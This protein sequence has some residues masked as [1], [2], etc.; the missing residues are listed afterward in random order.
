MYSDISFIGLGLIGGS[1]AKAIRSHYP[2]MKI[3]AFD[4]DASS[5][6]AA[7]NEGVADIIITE[8][9]VSAFE[10]TDVIFICTPVLCAEPYVRE[11]SEAK[12]SALITD[13]GSVKGEI[14]SLVEKYGLGNRF[15]GGHPMAGTEKSGYANSFG[16]LLENAN[17]VLT[18]A[19]EVSKDRVEELKGLILSLG[20]RVL[21]LDHERHDLA[22]AAIS[23]LPHVL[24]YSLINVIR[25]SD[26]RDNA[27]HLMAAGGLKDMTRIASSSPDMWEQICL[28]NKD[29]LL[30]LMDE[31]E[32]ELSEVRS[33]LERG[34]GKALNARFLA[35]KN[36]RDTF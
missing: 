20:C 24:A 7:K 27:M 35:G 18:P 23:H 21:V 16:N 33:E 32:K 30:L 22:A 3:R 25:K 34:D 8:F 5:L 31:F 36:Y 12:G 26:D 4:L 19:P 15:V 28:A 14:F 11:L 6:E 1:V 13:V 2:G 17:Y 9:S 10:G 29:K